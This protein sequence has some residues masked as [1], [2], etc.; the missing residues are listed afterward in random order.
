MDLG[1]YASYRLPSNLQQA[2]GVETAQQLAD[3]LGVKG[4][5]SAETAREGEV[6]YTA[7]RRGDVAA[8]RSFLTGTLGMTDAAADDALAKLDSASPAGA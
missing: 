7:Y 3:Q 6:A 1:H 8:A 5:L 2:F 4:E